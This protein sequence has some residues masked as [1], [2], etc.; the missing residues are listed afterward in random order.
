MRRGKRREEERG[1]RMIDGLD[2][3]DSR[4]RKGEP[5]HDLRKILA[6]QSSTNVRRDWS[7]SKKEEAPSITIANSPCRGHREQESYSRTKR[8][9][10]QMLKVQFF[11]L[12]SKI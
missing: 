5:E 9:I 8:F 6:N 4:I 11:W 12:L 7:R 1:N 3:D 2:R 10:F